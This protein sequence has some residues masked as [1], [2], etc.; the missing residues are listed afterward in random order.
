MATKQ[1]SLYVAC[2]KRSLMDAKLTE[3]IYIRKVLVSDTYTS[4]RNIH[5]WLDIYMAP[6]WRGFT[7]ALGIWRRRRARQS[8]FRTSSLTEW[9][10]IKY[11]MWNVLH[12]IA[13]GII[14]YVCTCYI[15]QIGYFRVHVKALGLHC[16]EQ[17]SAQIN[18]IYAHILLLY[19]ASFSANKS[20][21]QHTQYKHYTCICI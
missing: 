5:L 15:I 4:G 8:S 13:T 11:N 10:R 20:T 12:I 1:I 17:Q 7:P 21:L 2:G 14:I 19:I 6:L 3:L 18:Y 16:Y 9:L